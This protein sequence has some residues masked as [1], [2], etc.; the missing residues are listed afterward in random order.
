MKS[1]FNLFRTSAK[2]IAGGK[3]S[4]CLMNIVVTGMFIAV[5]MAIEALYIPVPFGRV[6]FAF[7][8]I[9]A[10]GMLYGPST[11]FLAGGICDIL[12]HIVRPDGAFLPVYT[13]IG[14]LQGLIYGIILYRRWGYMYSGGIS[15]GK[16]FTEMS[17]RLIF[18][19]LCDVIIINLLLNTAANMYYGFIPRQAFG[20]AVS[21][22][23]IKN[24]LELGADIPLLLTVMPVILAVYSKSAG[25]YELRH[26]K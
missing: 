5:Y 25:K 23:L 9:A 11:A 4:V 16:K 2:E 1:F 14:M 15:L 13:F 12:G 22:R 20:A 10:I 24:V 6:N 17:V 19:R 26:I 18:A 7:L 21:A 3:P 8:A